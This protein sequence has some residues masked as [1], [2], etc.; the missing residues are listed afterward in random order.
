MSHVVNDVQ[1]SLDLPSI[2]SSV[3]PNVVVGVFVEDVQTSLVDDVLVHDVLVS[4]IFPM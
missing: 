2:S 3:Q 1:H 4:S